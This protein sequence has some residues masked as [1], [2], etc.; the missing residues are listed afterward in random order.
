MQSLGRGRQGLHPSAR[1]GLLLGTSFAL[2]LATRALLRVLHVVHALAWHIPLDR[3][4]KPR[5]LRDSAVT[6]VGVTGI[7]LLGALA[8]GLRDS[9]GILGILPI[10]LDWAVVGILWFLVELA[11]P[12]DGGRWVDLVP[13]AVLF[14][15][16]TWGLQILTVLW[17]S[18]ALASKSDAFGAVGVALTI[19]AWSYV[20][21]RIVVTGATL[22]AALVDGRS[23]GT[24]R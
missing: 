9:F 13:G 17:Y 18:Q 3:A 24:A 21:G 6:I 5:I 20:L 19:L 16:G 15:L 2:V 23:S 11:L 4:K 10:S 1:L 12:H 8:A 22:N 7:L 14:A